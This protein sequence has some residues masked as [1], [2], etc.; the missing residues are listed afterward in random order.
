MQN[1][2]W[3]VLN[4]IDKV[5]KG[6]KVGSKTNLVSAKSGEGIEELLDKIHADILKK[7]KQLYNTD[8][9][10]SNARQAN[11]LEVTL[12][13]MEEAKKEKY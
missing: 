3:N 2:Q 8:A 5:E 10:I 12:A 1:N 7:T 9:I 6:I 4:K 11:E 13:C